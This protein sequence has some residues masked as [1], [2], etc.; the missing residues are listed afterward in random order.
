[1]V[2][3]RAPKISGLEVVLQKPFSKY[4]QVSLPATSTTSTVVRLGY[5]AFPT[6]ITGSGINAYSYS[7]YIRN[8]DPTNG[9]FADLL[10]G[11]V[12]FGKTYFNNGPNWE[13]IQTTLR[14][15]GPS[16][17]GPRLYFYCPANVAATFSV[18]N[19]SLLQVPLPTTIQPLATAFSNSAP[20]V[21]PPVA[22]TCGQAIIN[23]GFETGTFG[24]YT[25]PAPWSMVA[26]DWMIYSLYT[27]YK[28][29]GVRAIL[30][31]LPSSISAYLAGTLVD[32]EMTQGS[33]TVCPNTVYRYDAYLAM[34]Y[35]AAPPSCQLKLKINGVV[36]AAGA[37][38]S[39]S[40]TR[41]YVGTTSYYQTG[42]SETAVK[43]SIAVSCSNGVV[44][45][46]YG[47]QVGVD[48]VSFFPVTS[49]SQLPS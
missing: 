1:M 27:T 38:V 8:S 40:S 15:S 34:L 44:A 42:P 24:T 18:D 28:R 23:G 3:L 35:A 9:C 21:F 30:F 37:P 36:V 22:P 49:A 26:S 16:S 2:T 5:I 14:L 31:Q 7:A 45:G 48:D 25:P 11:A 6:V 47:I 29:S 10:F 39:Y 17:V 19:I 32:A 20:A 46:G 41:P 33:V 12:D 4:L 13:L 43:L